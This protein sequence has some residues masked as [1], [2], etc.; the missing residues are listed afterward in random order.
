MIVEKIGELAESDQ[1]AKWMDVDEVVK[2]VAGLRKKEL[3]EMLSSN[4]VERL[5]LL[6]P[7]VGKRE[8]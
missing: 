6:V 7:V 1:V 4:E 5:I 2:I 3:V 8:V